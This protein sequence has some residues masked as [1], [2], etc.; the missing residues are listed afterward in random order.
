LLADPKNTPSLLHL[1]PFRTGAKANILLSS[2]SL[3][4]QY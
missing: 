1:F 2:S 4:P 3:W